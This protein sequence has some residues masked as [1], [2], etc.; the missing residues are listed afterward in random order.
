MPDVDYG[1]LPSPDGPMAPSGSQPEP[2]RDAVE[3]A[4]LELHR[5]PRI[6]DQG[7]VV[8]CCVSIAVTG[9]LELLLARGGRP[10][11]L[12][13]MFHYYRARSEPSAL[14]S[15]SLLDGLQA[16]M[17]DGICSQQLHDQAITSAGASIMPSPEAIADGRKLAGS[18]Y[19]PATGGLIGHFEFFRLADHDR[20]RSWL[21]TLGSGWPILMGF[22]QTPG[23]AAIHA[24]LP[25]HGDQLSPRAP[26]GHAV[27]VI[28]HR[29]RRGFRI[30][31]SKG[32]G[33][34][35]RGTWWLPDHLLE[36]PLIQESWF[37]KPT[38]A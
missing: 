15:L 14:L 33:F 37:I 7:Q 24:G 8:P 13:P 17:R 25:R 31:D 32:R 29:R 20:R 27:L 6:R 16:A 1:W 26:V 10:P 35:K 9:A 5:R 2:G 23:Y 4:T 21:A 12:S 3:L 11:E 34:G 19:N 22:W 38:S 28:G 18:R 30:V 36:T